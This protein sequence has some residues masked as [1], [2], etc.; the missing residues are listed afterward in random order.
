MLL[1]LEDQLIEVE[2]IGW[3]HRPEL[4]L[5]DK[6]ASRGVKKGHYRLIRS[7]GV[8]ISAIWKSKLWGLDIP[9][10]LVNETEIEIVRPLKWHELL[11]CG[12]PLS[13]AVSGGGCWIDSGSY[14]LQDERDSV[15]IIL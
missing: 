14:C 5:N 7:D 15:S 13:L 1:D 4:L 3:F 12:I 2:F 6:A 9:Y 10:L 8:E 11:W